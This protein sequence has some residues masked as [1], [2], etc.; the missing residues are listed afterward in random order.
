MCNSKAAVDLHTQPS[1]SEPYKPA[2]GELL[3]TVYTRPPGKPL[4]PMPAIAAG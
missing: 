2:P 3:H 1:G 4:K